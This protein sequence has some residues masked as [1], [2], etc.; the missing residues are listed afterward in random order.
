MDINSSLKAKIPTTLNLLGWILYFAGHIKD[1][2]TN[3]ALCIVGISIFLCGCLLDI[4][5]LRMRKPMHET[6]LPN[7]MQDFTI[8]NNMNQQNTF[9]MAWNTIISICCGMYL[10]EQILLA[11]EKPTNPDLIRFQITCYFIVLMSI[12]ILF[13][14]A[15]GFGFM[16]ADYFITELKTLAKACY[17]SIL[18]GSVI[19]IIAFILIL[20]ALNDIVYVRLDY[21]AVIISGNCFILL[22]FLGRVGFN[23]INY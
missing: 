13:A 4:L 18:V 3:T 1:S 5:F 7:Q 6:L 14:T 8:M 22:G 9:K 11:L 10:F 16:K 2:N 20:A 23:E 12:F 15:A 17:S 19:N 21:Y